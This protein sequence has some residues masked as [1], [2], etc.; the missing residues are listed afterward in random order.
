MSFPQMEMLLS[1][2]D[3][4][5]GPFFEKMNA[6][7]WLGWWLHIMLFQRNLPLCRRLCVSPGLLEVAQAAFQHFQPPSL[8]RSDR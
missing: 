4:D 1:P 5:F 7:A 8:A 2:G 6:G 3:G